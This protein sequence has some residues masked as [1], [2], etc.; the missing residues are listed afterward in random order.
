MD[1]FSIVD[2]LHTKAH[3]SEPVQNLVLA[4]V[5]ASL[6]FQFTREITSISVVH[7]D[8][9]LSFSCLKCLDEFND[10]GVLQMLDDLG[11]LQCLFFLVFAHA[12]DIDDLHD[13][14]KLVW[15]PFNQVSFSKRALSKEFDFSVLFEFFPL[16]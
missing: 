7:D 8:A 10:I 5:T 3:L 12:L 1:D 4:E 2:M 11:L 16:R 13:A 9:E 14:L 15:H 6:L